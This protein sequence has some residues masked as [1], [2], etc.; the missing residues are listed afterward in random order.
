MHFLQFIISK[1]VLI[2]ALLFGFW[3]TNTS[4][5]LHEQTRKTKRA[6]MRYFRLA[7]SVPNSTNFFTAYSIWKRTKLY[8]R[9]NRSNHVCA[10]LLGSRDTLHETDAIILLWNYVC[11]WNGRKLMQ[12]RIL[13]FHRF[14][15]ETELIE[16]RVSLHQRLG[17]ESLALLLLNMLAV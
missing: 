3:F 16:W 12:I 10:W 4:S 14:W 17:R 5:L 15:L 6:N 1:I 11:F 8:R 2:D 7:L 13:I 9:A